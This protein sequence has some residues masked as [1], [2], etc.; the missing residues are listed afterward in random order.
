MAYGQTATAPVT[1]SD[2][3]AALSDDSDV[4]QLSEFKVVGQRASLATAQEFKRNSSLTI[5]SI[6]A[7][8]IG[9]LPDTNVA[10]ALQRITGIQM[11]IDRGEGGGAGGI[12]IR[13]LPQMVALVDGHEILTAAGGRSV[14]FQDIP[15]ALVAGLDVYKTSAANM[16]EGGLG[17]TIDVRMRQPFD[18]KGLEVAGSFRQTY[19]SLVRQS[20]PSYNLL[21]SNRW[22]V[23]GLG[24]IGALVSLTEQIRPWREDQAS[25][26][27]PTPSTT[28][29]PGQTVYVPAGEYQPTSYGYR[30]RK[31]INA[32]L[33]W[34]PDSNFE[35]YLKGNYQKFTTHQDSYGLSMSNGTPVLGSTTLFPGTNDVQSVT[36]TN[37]GF[38]VIDAARDTEDKNKQ[39]ELGG[40][41]TSGNLT[42]KADV[43]YT[44]SYNKLYYA[45]IN[46]TGAVP[47]F[48][49]NLAP[50]IPTTS[51]YGASLLDPSL[52]T[53]ST[54]A[55]RVLPFQ[56]R[57]TAEQLD[58]EYKFSDSFLNSVMVGFRYA[59]RVADNVNGLIFGDT[60]ISI[61]V[62]SIPGMV[63]SN[64]VPDFFP[65]E[66]N[67]MFRQYL[68]GNLSNA[69]DPVALRSAF[70]ITSPLPTAAA[71]P[72][73][74]WKIHEDTSAL[75]M[76]GKF[77]GTLGLK[78]DG[79]VGVRGVRTKE[80]VSGYQT[81]P[82]TSTAPSM[83]APLAINSN[84]TDWLPSL[85]SRVHLTENTF[86]RMAVSKTIT[87]PDFSALSPSLSLVPNPT[88]P[89]QNAGSAGNPNLKPLRANNYDLSI[90]QYFSKTTSVYIA[91]FYKTANGFVSNSSNPEVYN[92]V[93][94]QVSRPQNTNGAKIKGFEAGY[95]QFFDFLPELFRGFGVQLNYTY[96][97]SSTP[98]SVVGQTV[99]LSNLSKNSYNAV[100][101]Y[102]NHGLSARVAYNWRDKYF[103]GSANVVGLGSVPN[104]YKENGWLDASVSYELTKKIRISIEGTNLTNTIREQYWSVLTRPSSFYQEDV[105]VMG[106]I[107]FSL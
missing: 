89:L 74:L 42:I 9:K 4:I 93:T 97:D 86:L 94:Y 55:Y 58:A 106:T 40:R 37:A 80:S 34:R 83:I 46:I 35:F 79:N 2:N 51:V 33:E 29:I 60:S 12:T 77:G 73:S 95:Q 47:T 53:Y 71:N 36:F 23:K 99:P 41:W 25:I 102:E 87:R 101:M 17:G 20:K 48:N 38:T 26:G 28:L 96:V 85:N 6:V 88:N 49:Y 62:S 11:A 50:H 67:P 15:A 19:G 5:D 31:G 66:A 59:P 64:P 100:L 32:V 75:Y 82:A 103:S 76:M 1:P 92:G 18:F 68:V 8:D 104:Y 52:Y 78:F 107:S 14:N 10:E 21:V 81:I 65:G 43:D 3:K 57:M 90:E 56:T 98:S 69:R 24:E 105:Q 63:V 13:G 61:P 84:Y 27:S 45:G 7:D 30:N 44:S 54:V 16:I 70:G 72:I 39:A 22:K 91:G